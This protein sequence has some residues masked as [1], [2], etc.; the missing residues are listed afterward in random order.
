MEI[1]RA[2]MIDLDKVVNILNRVAQNLQ[3]NGIHQ[4]DYP[5]D[6]DKI[7]KEIKSDQAFILF[8]DR[9]AI[10]T[11]FIREIDGLSELAV[12]PQ[13]NYLNKIAILPEYQGK[14][15]GAIIIDYACSFSH[16]LNKTL[17]LDCWAGNDKLKAFYAGHGFK[18][19]GDFPED[20][21]YISVY[22]K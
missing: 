22:Q 10:G 9:K 13:S 2:E 11:F 21:Y 1:R 20:D 8:N 16:N 12:A 4:W 3:E 17:Y 7:E 18:Y 15:I 6:R 14:N 5:W 19:L